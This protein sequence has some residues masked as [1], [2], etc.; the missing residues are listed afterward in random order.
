MVKI[1]KMSWG[2]KI[3]G[4]FFIFALVLVITLFGFRI[5]YVGRVYPGIS[6]NGV[7]LGGL[8]Q[9][10]AQIL[11]DSQ[12]SAYQTKS[13]EII[14]PSG[15]VNLS[16]EKLGITYN[17]KL[18]VE[19]SMSI[20]R[21]GWFNNQLAEQFATMIG[22]KEPINEVTLDNNKVASNLVAINNNFA[23]PDL[24]AKYVASNGEIEIEKSQRG[25]RVDFHS[26]IGA[27]KEYFGQQQN[28]TFVLPVLTVEPQLSA[29]ALENQ[30]SIISPFV[31]NPLRLSYADKTW[32]AD[33]NTIVSWLTL[34]SSNLPLKDDIISRNY[35]I[36]NHNN[37]LSFDKKSIQNYI[38]SLS[39]Q[40]N[41]EPVNAQLSISGGK[42]VVFT[43]SRD[44]RQL[45]IDKSTAAVYEYL[46]NS[47]YNKPVELA[48]NVTKA[49]VSDDNI[50][51]LGIKELISEGV[52]YFPGSSANRIQNVRVGTSKF[53]GLLIRPG[54]VFSFNKYL[55]EVSAAT[56]YAEGVVILEN[57][58]EKQFGGGLCQVSSTAYRAALLAGL[59]I[60]SRTNHAFAVSYY[61]EP[62]GVPGVDATIY[63]PYPDMQFTNDT[64]KYI[65]IQT[66]MI[67]T[68]LRFRFYGTKTKS[69]VIRGPYFISGSNDHTKPSETV[70]Y[71]DVIDTNGKV[72][73]TDTTFT[74]YKSSLEFPLIN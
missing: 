68:T 53:N 71:R 5:A 56:G 1:S 41:I 35:R 47:V 64:G 55:G 17:N 8:K 18:A 12:T 26:S 69:G 57:K 73:K 6:A 72:I 3:L 54:E 70:F 42:A 62:Y 23:K 10:E 43:Q 28:K 4:A 33:I 49:E 51:K 59:P 27:I 44:G 24:N 40:I 38:T 58:E 45:D 13:Q 15:T 2:E 7:Y 52:S 67:G 29:Q 25:K 32:G 37:I 20:G 66:E 50:D 60:V 16:A 39:E 11:L 34:P 21:Q 36:D 48:V 14:V 31:S 22:L 19:K 30:K 61:T 46:K 65:L 74:K 63:L 9:N